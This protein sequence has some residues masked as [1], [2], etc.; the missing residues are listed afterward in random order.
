MRL[1]R[2]RKL[3]GKLPQI[4]VLPQVAHRGAQMIRITQLLPAHAD[5]LLR[6]AAIKQHHR[7]AAVSHLLGP[8]FQIAILRHPPS[9]AAQ[10]VLIH[11]NHFFIGENVLVSGVILRRSL[12]AI[13]GA[14]KIAHKL[15]CER[16]SVLVMPPLPTSS[17]SGSFQCPGPA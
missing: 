8:N 11:S 1:H 4:F 17:M 10:R 6:L 5:F 3:S 2:R 13:R 12:P 7:P 15:K 16:Y 14:A 9:F